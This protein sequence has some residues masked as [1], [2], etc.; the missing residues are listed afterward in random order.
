MRLRHRLRLAWLVVLLALAAGAGALAALGAR[1]EQRAEQRYVVV[2]GGAEKVRPDTRA[3][4]GRAASLFA[5][6]NEFESFQVVVGAGSRPLRRLSIVP[7]GPLTGPAGTIAERNITVYREGYY[8]ARIASSVEGRAG[9]WP[10]PL[11]PA[12]DRFYGERR[13]AFP[14]DVPPGENRVAWIDVFVPANTR[15]GRY[16]GELLVSAAGMRARIPVR[17]TVLRLRLPSTA[18]LTSSFGLFYTPCLTEP[19]RAACTGPAEAEWRLRALFARAA[20]DDRVSISQPH[21]RPPL[22]ASERALFRRFVLPLLQG[23]SATRLRWARLTSL[24]IDRA[25]TAAWRQL[26]QEQGFAARAFSHACDEP[27]ESEAAWDTCLWNAAAARAAWPGLPV[28]VTASVQDAMRFAAIDDIDI[29]VPLV[30][31]MDDKPGASD[32]AGDQR[33]R[34][35]AFLRRPGHRVW[36]Y[37][38]CESHGCGIESG[39]YYH[40]WPGYVIDA[41]ASAARAMGWLS[42]LYRTSGEL[43]YAVDRR[44]PSAWVNQY[45]FGGNGDGTLFYLGT[46]QQIGGTKTIPVESLRLKQIRDGYEDYEYLRYLSRRGRRN[47]AAAVA[48]ALFPTLHDTSRSDGEIQA[49]RRRLGEL[50][51]RVAGGPRP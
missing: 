33:P 7:A 1:A 18:S 32:K 11:V 25:S 21:H 6:R 16:A 13:H 10:D 5:A 19:A 29:L 43:Y 41:P 51:A 12:V 23:S 50:V 42:F 27:G 48:R 39:G 46:R 40:G 30:N 15:A 49:A 28:L 34:Y 31:Q 9:L 37:T 4:G 22:T 2:V 26:A 36:L 20:L 44:L 35:D 38:S 17:L 14:V 8:T 3:S 45:A 24:Q 47:E